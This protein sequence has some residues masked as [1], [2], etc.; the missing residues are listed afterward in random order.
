[1]KEAIAIIMPLTLLFVLKYMHAPLC[2]VSI[3]K[4]ALLLPCVFGSDRHSWQDDCLYKASLASN[5]AS[6]NPDM[7][8]MT[9]YTL[10]LL[11]QLVEQWGGLT[12]QV[13]D[14]VNYLMGAV[15][16]VLK[17]VTVDR[18]GSLLQLSAP[19]VDSYHRLL[20]P[21]MCPIDDMGHNLHQDSHPA[22][23]YRHICILFFF[24]LQE[25]HKL[26]GGQKFG[27]FCKHFKIRESRKVP[28][29]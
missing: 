23:V 26:L 22:C 4:H 14:G 2:T 5:G 24:F 17:I 1:M 27:N 18:A 19:G 13:K 3:V 29:N 12:G 6:L 15:A 21:M 25:L 10:H 28:T 8:W 7:F 9:A 20:L 16:V 11:R